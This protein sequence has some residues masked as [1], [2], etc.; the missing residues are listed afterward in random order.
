MPPILVSIDART[1]HP[2]DRRLS[3]VAYDDP[4]Q[5]SSSDQFPIIP[6]PP[7][8]YFSTIPVIMDLF[9]NIKKNCFT[10]DHLCKLSCTLLR[11]FKPHPSISLSPNKPSALSVREM[12]DPKN[13][14]C[15]S[16]LIPKDKLKLDPEAFLKYHVKYCKECKLVTKLSETCYFN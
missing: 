10:P 6:I 12:L 13:F 8:K 15:G 4:V 16:T 3:N 14:N 5:P 2:R 7:V 9:K 11:A 1:T